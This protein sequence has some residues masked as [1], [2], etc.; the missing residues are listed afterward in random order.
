MYMEKVI[1]YMKRVLSCVGSKMGL[2]T[3]C[4]WT[5]IENE[6]STNDKSNELQHYFCCESLGICMDISPKHLGH[7]RN[8]CYGASF[9]SNYIA[10]G[11][12]FP[13]TVTNKTVHTSRCKS[14]FIPIAW[15][16]SGGPAPEQN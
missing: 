8:K 1:L 6:H 16:R 11:T 5:F 4:C 14:S 10:H 7:F 12:S 9:L 3:V 2:F 13:V 15:G